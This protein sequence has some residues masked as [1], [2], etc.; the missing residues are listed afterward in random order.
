MTAS[1]Q[2]E[3]SHV[4]KGSSQSFANHFTNLLRQNPV[5]RLHS[6]WIA[7]GLVFT[8]GAPQFVSLVDAWA[9]RAKRA[10]EN[11]RKRLRPFINAFPEVSWQRR[12]VF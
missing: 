12:F 6:G 7:L 4:P 3:N 2:K 8:L 11:Y 1:P 9:T 5:R 10:V